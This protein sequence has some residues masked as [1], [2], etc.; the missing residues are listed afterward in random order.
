[1]VCLCFW[2]QISSLAFLKTVHAGACQLRTKVKSGS[3]SKSTGRRRP[4]FREGRDGL[5]SVHP[6]L[7]TGFRH[8]A[9]AAPASAGSTQSPRLL[10][11]A[12]HLTHPLQVG[13][14]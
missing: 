1:M 12:E 7:Q 9:A 6:A 4:A 11:Q 2:Y 14:P 13:Q 8:P 10:P 3:S 5:S